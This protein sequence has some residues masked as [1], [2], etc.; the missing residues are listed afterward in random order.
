LEKVLQDPGA[1]YIRIIDYGL[2]IGCGACEAACD[3][4]H[5]GKPFIKVYRTSLGLDIPVSCFHCRKAPCI[6]VCPT[7]AMTR[8][9]EGAVYVIEARC[10]GCMACLYACPFGIPELDPVARVS[11]K[12]DL[13]RVLRSEGL[14][15]ACAA[16]CP[17][18]AIVYGEEA[19]AFNTVKR[20]VAEVFA[21]T[22]F[23]A[24][25]TGPPT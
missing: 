23:E 16:I 15:P 1:K 6:E 2:C 25:F 8:D 7:G 21:K 20:R 10:I 14:E 19:L 24:L 11:I 13:C 18:K 22:R 17:T 12:C 4:I 9:R 3:F 5:E